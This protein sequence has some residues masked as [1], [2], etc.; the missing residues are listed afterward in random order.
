MT[1][2]RT[3]SASASTSESTSQSTAASPRL[4]SRPM[5][6]GWRL[7]ALLIAAITVGTGL[8][9][10]EVGG[11]NGAYEGI[12]V[13]ARTSAVLFLLT[14][15][16]SSVYRLWPSKGTKWIRRN[17]RYLGVAFA[18]SHTAHA[19]FIIS[20]IH[21]NSGLFAARAERAPHA[22]YVLDTIAY[23][24]IIAMTVTSFDAVARRM[25]YPT[26]HRV[27]LTGSYVIWLTF[28][29]AYWRRAVQYP[30]FYGP[31]LMVVL[32]ALLVRSIAKAQR[33]PA[34]AGRDDER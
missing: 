5:L 11:V 32:A 18:G 31:L 21:L 24:F 1:A 7:T 8:V 12:R 19:A 33:S 16:A 25:K 29:I 13:T 26:W 23:L 9:A 20:S 14:F 2:I 3:T 4:L 30:L 6:N 10:I 27:H 28:F 17:R 34:D 15:T 22:I